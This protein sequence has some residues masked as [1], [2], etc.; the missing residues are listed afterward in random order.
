MGLVIKKMQCKWL[1]IST[2]GDEE[3]GR[4]SISRAMVSSTSSK[5]E[6]RLG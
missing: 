5:L 2:E 6:A 1:N 4:C 3:R